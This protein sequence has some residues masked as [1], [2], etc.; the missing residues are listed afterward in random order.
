MTVY[1]ARPRLRKPPVP[2]DLPPPVLHRRYELGNEV[3][4]GGCA[5][6]YH[7]WDIRAGKPVALKR[8]HWG[9]QY[10]AALFHEAETL[11][12]LHHPAIPAFVEFFEEA[13]GAY[14]AQEWKDGT[15]LTERQRFSL[16]EILWIGLQC[17]EVL[18]HLHQQ[19]LV[20][21]DIA[22]GNILLDREHQRLCV[23]DFGLA[24]LDYSSPHAEEAPPLF[25]SIAGTPGYVAPEHWVEGTV[26]PAGD[27]YSLG[28]LL[29]CALTGREPPDAVTVPSFAALWDDPRTLP[30]G[31][32]PLLELLD[33]MCAFQP[34]DRPDATTVCSTLT[35]LQAE[36]V[37]GPMPWR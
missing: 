21:R 22:P 19:R 29:G 31:L 15:P 12:R 33:Q 3:G 27:I 34:E 24:C 10:H 9:Q 6:V 11:A 30:A 13:G 1:R 37:R 14:L 26:S 28:M 36:L 4:R 25:A 23:L 2:L 17:T 18:A 8:A 32:L 16:T 20:H 7:A 35:R 5:S